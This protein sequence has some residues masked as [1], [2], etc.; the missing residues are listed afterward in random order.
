MLNLGLVAAQ[1]REDGLAGSLI[2]DAEER[3]RAVGDPLGLCEC[4]DA[5]ALLAAV[6]GRRDEAAERFAEA[7]QARER[8]HAPLPPVQRRLIERL[9]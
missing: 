6:A 3:F 9:L 8:I 7:E 5:R 1:S 2:A 4:L